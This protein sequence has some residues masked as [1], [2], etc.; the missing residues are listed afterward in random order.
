MYDGEIYQA[1]TVEHEE[2]PSTYDEA[3]KDV[4]TP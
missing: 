3:I 4:V 1:E 2:D